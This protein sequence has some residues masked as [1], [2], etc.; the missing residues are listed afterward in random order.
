MVC[1][2]F[3]RLSLYL[4][5]LHPRMFCFVGPNHVVRF[6]ATHKRSKIVQRNRDLPI[7]FYMGVSK[8]RGAPNGW[9]MMENPIKVDDLGVPLFLETP[10]WP[11]RL[12]IRW[13]FKKSTKSS[14]KADPIGLQTSR[15]S[16]L[17][18]SKTRKLLHPK[19]PQSTLSQFQ[20]PFGRSEVDGF[21]NQLFWT[22]SFVDLFH[23]S[24][25][26]MTPLNFDKSTFDA[27]VVFL[28]KKHISRY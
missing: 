23:H 12:Q 10:I 11:I 19:D 21:P 28:E 1:T 22:P 5:R 18:T 6:L 24:F 16:L 25:H 7:S 15:T 26:T 9:L 20:Q 17:T 2:W 3:V 8:N 14:L 4:P 13:I 27:D